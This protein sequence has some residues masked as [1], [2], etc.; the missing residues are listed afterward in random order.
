MGVASLVLYPYMRQ[1]TDDPKT[2]H[3]KIDRHWTKAG[4]QVA[5]E[6]IFEKLTGLAN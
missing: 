2:L 3:F 1:A 6:A 4:H 5:A